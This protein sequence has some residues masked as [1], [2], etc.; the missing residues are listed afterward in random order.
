MLT[1]ISWQ[2][3]LLAVSI[4]LTSYYSA[5]LILYYK[6]EI[7]AFFSPVKKPKSSIETE[8]THSVMGEPKDIFPPA[9]IPSD[10]LEFSSENQTELTESLNQ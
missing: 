6:V 3:Y 10:E 7:Q 8:S 5:V 9:S 4:L 1:F 2:Q